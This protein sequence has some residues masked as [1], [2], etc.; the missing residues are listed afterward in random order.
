MRSYQWV[1]R[2]CYWHC[3]VEAS[4]TADNMHTCLSFT[5][6]YS[7]CD[8]TTPPPLVKQWVWSATVIVNVF[9]AC[10][11]LQQRDNLVLLAACAE[12]ENKE[13]VIN[14]LFD[15]LKIMQLLGGVPVSW[16]W[17]NNLSFDW[18]SV[19]CDQGWH[20]SHYETSPQTPPAVLLHILFDTDWNP[21]KKPHMGQGIKW[22]TCLSCTLQEHPEGI[23]GRRL[24]LLPRHDHSNNKLK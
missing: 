5:C 15:C 13:S 3:R 12:Q 1:P 8:V 21:Q 11:L 7:N 20:S 19:L 23:Q 2:S 10:D 16:N 14:L 24:L 4:L 17:K 9:L 6:F 22:E 18:I